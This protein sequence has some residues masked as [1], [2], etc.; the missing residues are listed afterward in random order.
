MEI[1]KNILVTY[2]KRE[3][4]YVA[5]GAK[6]FM[7]TEAKATTRWRNNEKEYR[8]VAP[9][10]FEWDGATIPRWAWSIIGYYPGG[11]MTAPSL[12]HDLIYVQK[13]H[14][15]N[16]VTGENEYISRKHCD[17]LFYHHMIRSGI[18]EKKA[19]AM[20]QA[21]RFFGRFYWNDTP[22]FN[23]KKKINDTRK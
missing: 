12:W 23:P 4:G 22:L 17:E 2:F 1:G 11:Q 9:S 20:Y 14:I 16:S 18:S 10:N 7:L 6:K 19:K 5:L 3:V 21:I 15:F 13:G 8:L